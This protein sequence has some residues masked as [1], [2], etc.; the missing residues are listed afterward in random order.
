M[1]QLFRRRPPNRELME[2]LCEV[3]NDTYFLFLSLVDS[4]WRSIRSDQL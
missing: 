4:A 1:G 3:H 2:P